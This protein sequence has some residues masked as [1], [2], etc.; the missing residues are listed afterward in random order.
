M[1]ARRKSIILSSPCALRNVKC[2]VPCARIWIK[3][4]KTKTVINPALGTNYQVGRTIGRYQ[5]VLF[6]ASPLLPPP[7]AQTAN[8]SLSNAL[9]VGTKRGI[10][11]RLGSVEKSDAADA[12]SRVQALFSGIEGVNRTLAARCPELPLFLWFN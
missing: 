11:S 3:N 5:F 2:S 9:V 6:G 10:E 1:L 7:P 12:A 4:D 8:A